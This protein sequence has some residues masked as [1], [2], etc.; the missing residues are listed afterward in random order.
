MKKEVSFKF[1]KML[2]SKDRLKAIKGGFE[3]FATCSVD[4]PDLTKV[5]CTG[6]SCS[7]GS[8]WVQCDNG[9]KEYC[10]SVG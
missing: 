8:D 10:K 1:Q 5:S 9:N 7:T 2:L 6:G 3:D 4:C